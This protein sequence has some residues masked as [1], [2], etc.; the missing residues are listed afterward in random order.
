MK[1]LYRRYRPVRLDD[2]VGQDQVVKPLVG[3]LKAGKIS[4][5]YLFIGPRGCGKTSVARILAHEVNGFKYEIEDDYVDIIE[6]DGR[7]MQMSSTTL[8]RT[9]NFLSKVS[10][11]SSGAKTSTATTTVPNA[12]ILTVCWP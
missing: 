1:S 6:I 7:S 2:V 12:P 9:W 5:A 11:T 3:A 10:A 8:S 4:H